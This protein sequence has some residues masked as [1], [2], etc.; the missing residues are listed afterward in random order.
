MV[1]ID[2][3]GGDGAD[4]GIDCLH[5]LHRDT[6]HFDFLDPCDLVPVDSERSNPAHRSR[7]SCQR[8][9]HFCI[10]LLNPMLERGARCLEVAG[11]R[12]EKQRAVI[13]QSL[14]AYDDA[15]LRGGRTDKAGD[16]EKR[17]DRTLARQA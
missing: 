4:N 9:P 13:G 14:R 8:Y 5:R 2:F 1:R 17:G 10:P 12:G 15:L 3:V 6:V 11:G 7:P 16:D